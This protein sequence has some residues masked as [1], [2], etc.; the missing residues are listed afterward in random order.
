MQTY[1]EECIYKKSK[2]MI[3]DHKKLRLNAN[4]AMHGKEIK[5]I[6][7]SLKQKR[8]YEKV[9]FGKLLGKNKNTNQALGYQ[10]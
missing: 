4:Y 5:D 10:I 9:K 8:E 6:E 2:R 7:F 3:L 1:S